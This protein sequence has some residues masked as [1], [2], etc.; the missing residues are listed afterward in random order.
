MTCRPAREHDL[1]HGAPDG[2]FGPAIAK[3]EGYTPDCMYFRRCSM[4]G[5]C[6]ASPGHLV[7][8]R[9]IE[10]LLPTDGRPGTHFAYL[11]RVAEMLRHDQVAL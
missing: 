9:L 11:R 6:F 3:C 10:G 2:R 1:R 4:G 7:A 5:V 8:A